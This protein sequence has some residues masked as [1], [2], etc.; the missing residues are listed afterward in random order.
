MLHKQK[1]RDMVF[2]FSILIPVM[3]LF[4]IIRFIPIIQ[5]FVYSFMRKSMI[6]PGQ[7]FIWFDNY[8]YVLKDEEFRKAF[9]NT[10]FIA[11]FSVFGSVVVGLF[12]ASVVNSGRKGMRFWQA[13]CFC[14]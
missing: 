7:S 2:A 12:L 4:A 3:T 11:V 5:S 14:L 8:A 6:R 1:T 10:I 13:L 9:F